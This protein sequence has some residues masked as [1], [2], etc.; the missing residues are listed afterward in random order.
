MTWQYRFRNA[1]LGASALLFAGVSIAQGMDPQIAASTAKGEWVTAGG[2]SGFQRY[3]PLDQINARNVGSLEIAW[4]ARLL[5]VSGG[6]DR[7]NIA[8]PLMVGGKLYMPHGMLQVSAMDPATGKA[9]WTY[10]PPPYDSGRRGGLRPSRS[11]AYWTDGKSERIIQN[12]VDGRL[13]SIDAKTGKG[14][15]AFG[16]KGQVFL[17]RDLGRF[18]PYVGSNSP[19]TIVGDVVVAQF[20][21]DLTSPDK[22]ST[23]GFIRGYD[24]RTGKL[25]W[26]FHTIPQAGEFG[27]DTWGD[28]SWAYTGNTGA[29]TMMSADQQLGYVYIPVESPSNDFYGGHRPGAGLFGESIVAVDAKTGKRVWHYQIVHHGLWDYDPPAA[30]ILHDLTV[31]GRIVKAVTVLTKQGYEFVFNRV[32]GEPIWPIEERPAPQAA[33]PGDRQWPTQPFPTRPAALSPTGYRDSDLID[34]TPALKKEAQAIAGKY[35][36][37]PLYTPVTVPKPGML[38]TWVYPSMQGGPNWP[39]GAFDPDT[40]MLYVPSRNLPYAGSLV[41]GDPQVTDL[42]FTRPQSVIIRGP[43]GLPIN[44][45][46]WSLVTAT[47]MDRGVHVWQKAIGGAPDFVRDNPALKGLNLD[48]ASM[49]KWN[50]RPGILATKT[51]VFMGESG[52]YGDPGGPMFRAYDKATGKVVWEFEMPS[53]PQAT[54]M[55]YRYKGR[56]YIVMTVSARNHPA[57]LVALALPARGQPRRTTPV[58]PLPPPDVPAPPQPAPAAGG[59]PMPLDTPGDAPPPE[60]GPRP[61]AGA[62]LLAEGRRLFASTCAACHGARGEGLAGQTP[63]VADIN[64]YDTVYGKVANGGY[65]MPSMKGV[66]TPDQM[67]AVSRFVA[68]GGLRSKP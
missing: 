10:T 26:T 7:L 54:P 59:R 39:G 36:K 30:P 49:G 3:S 34:F 20:V 68:S 13:L 50:I 27:N 45:P 42:R 2:D 51:L 33:V 53:L 29:W 25:L 5:P 8:T 67:A 12:T 44:R 32:T 60:G 38:G 24:V 15:D 64:D 23:P 11:V 37:G 63:G 65:S 4:R 16:Y 1:V 61:E 9:L 17:R 31:N 21:S 41:A 22:E 55:T 35:E 46:P 28:G 6:A 40:H 43:Q 47:N 56:Q 66:L 58:E 62:A 48:F 52:G 19:P 14:D 18:V 57:E